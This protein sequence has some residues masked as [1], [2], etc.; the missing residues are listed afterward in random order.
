MT[1]F[2]S[3][4]KI[5]DNL[6]EQRKELEDKLEAIKSVIKEN[7]EEHTISEAGDGI[8]YIIKKLEKILELE[9]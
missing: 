4:D 7:K 6:R 3:K 9:E 1:H 5:I 2:V 8:Q